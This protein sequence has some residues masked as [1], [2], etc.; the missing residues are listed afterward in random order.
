MAYALAFAWRFL[1][2][3]WIFLSDGRPRCI[4]FGWMWLSGRFSASGDAAEIFNYAKFSAAQIAFFGHDNCPFI[5][6]FVYPPTYLFMTYLLGFMP[7][8]VAFTAWLVV[9]LSLYGIAIYLI[10]PRYTAVIAAMAPF[11]VAVNAD[12]G[13]NG[14]LTAAL[15]GF[16]LVSLE[17]RPFLSG[18][19]LG[20][21]IYKPH[22][23]VLFP[24]A[25]LVSRKWRALASAPAVCVVL[26][27]A[28]EIAFGSQGWLSFFQALVHRESSLSPDKKVE[29]ALHTVFGLLR[30]AQ[31]GPLVSWIGHLA[32]AAM[33]MLTV[34]AVWAKPIPYS[35]KAAILCIGSVMVS[36]YLLFY[37][38]CVLSLAVAFLV[39]D[40]ILRGFL[41]GERTVLL[42]CFSALFLVAVPIGP[43]ICATLALLVVRRIVRGQT[44]DQGKDTGL[45]ACLR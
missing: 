45:A 6:P 26:A 4:D 39:R 5:T 43:I 22:I 1:H 10:L 44:L 23:G 17:R 14:Y 11:F 25:L 32:V 3:Q 42:A 12:F 37:D 13:H 9:T 30:W 33:V 24:V 38:F 20:A 8:P 35:L 2:G 16:S 15:I 21:L 29:L 41:P 7:Y 28:A 40:G 36:P 27:W 19:F 18:A 34:C 31:A